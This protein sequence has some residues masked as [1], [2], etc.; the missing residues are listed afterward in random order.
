MA[1]TIVVLSADKEPPPSITFDA[2][3]VV[4]GRG[5]GADVRLPDPSVSHRHAT[6]RQ[7][8]SDYLVVDEG[9]T[10]GTYVGAVRLA[11]QSPRVVRDGDRIRVGH[12]ELEVRLDPSAPATQSPLATRELALELVAAAMAASGAPP[13]VRVFARPRK[14]PAD[15]AASETAPSEELVL[16]ELGRQYV[17]GRAQTCDLPLADPDCSRR[18]V[19]LVRRGNGLFVRDLGSKNGTRLGDE[20]LDPR[21]EHL[22]PPGVDLSLGNTL[23]SYEDS[24]EGALAE[25]ESAADEPVDGPPPRG[26]A[27]PSSASEGSGALDEPEDLDLDG[28]AP[29][30][31]AA[32]VSARR[33][34]R[35]PLDPGLID[36]LVGALALIVLG[37]SL[38]GLYWLL[39]S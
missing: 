29:A 27:A 12:V 32:Q 18:H 9:S 28:P 14:A 39:G 4:I 34:P 15:D 33:A 5:E 17:I 13:S 6:L 2:P 3:R 1:V 24:L 10:N 7:R 26:S 20:P 16:E 37:L 22:W 19:S 11:P 21:K 38:L 8:G 36:F 23:L 31:P 35:R 30:T 25:L